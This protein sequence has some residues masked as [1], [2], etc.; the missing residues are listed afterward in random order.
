MIIPKRYTCTF[1]TNDSIKMWISRNRRNVMS[2][3]TTWVHVQPCGVQNKVGR[4]NPR[5]WRCKGDGVF[6]NT[7]CPLDQDR[8]LDFPKFSDNQICS[9]SNMHTSLRNPVSEPKLV[10]QR[11]N[12]SGPR[13]LFFL[14]GWQ[15]KSTYSDSNTYCSLFPFL[16]GRKGWKTKRGSVFFR[17]GLPFFFNW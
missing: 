6:W 15:R 4:N 10:A 17:I 16:E 8:W 1:H 13:S 11:R 14:Q 2:V 9:P 7:Y 12:G 5:T 3:G